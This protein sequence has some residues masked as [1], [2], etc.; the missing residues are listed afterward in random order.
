HD[1]L[2]GGGRKPSESQRRSL[3]R[4]LDKLNKDRIRTLRE[5]KLSKKQIDKIVLQIKGYARRVD[6]A[7]R[8]SADASQRVG[9]LDPS[10]MQ[11]V[12]R[13]MQASKAAERRLTRK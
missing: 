3:R 11:K 9:G 2:E 10:A 6:R 1:E 5:L 13:D 7:E 4:Q 8:T 12:Q